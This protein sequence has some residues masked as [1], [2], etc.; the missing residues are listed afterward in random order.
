MARSA[1]RRFFEREP[2]PNAPNR[3]ARYPRRFR[4]CGPDRRPSAG[5]DHTRSKQ[6]P[7]TSA[8]GNVFA[9]FVSSLGTERSS[10]EP[11]EQ[12]LFRLFPMCS[13]FV[14]LKAAA[15]ISDPAYR[16]A[17]KKVPVARFAIWRV[18]SE[19]SSVATARPSNQKTNQTPLAR[20]IHV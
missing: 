18:G 11:R 12:L 7:E 3:P 2:P 16:L 13:S 6:A 19:L 4:R 14:R 1:L 8:N 17:E 20:L 9:L 15:L 5:Q 10:A